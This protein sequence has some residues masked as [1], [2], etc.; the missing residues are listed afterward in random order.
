MRGEW[1]GAVAAGTGGNG[2][3]RNGQMDE[4]HRALSTLPP[5]RWTLKGARLGGVELGGDGVAHQPEG[6]GPVT[7]VQG[8]G[9]DQAVAVLRSHSSG[10]Q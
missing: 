6:W 1:V 4:R 7:L 10:V 3:L 5:C 8:D 9:T 2:G